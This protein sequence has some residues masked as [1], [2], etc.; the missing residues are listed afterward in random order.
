MTTDRQQWLGQGVNLVL[1]GKLADE[2]AWCANATTYCREFKC[3]ET[4]PID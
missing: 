1:A 2:V 4:Q 3:H